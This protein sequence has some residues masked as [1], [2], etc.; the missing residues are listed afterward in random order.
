VLKRVLHDWNDA[1]CVQILSNAH[2]AAPSHAKVLIIE[3]VVPGPET[4]HFSK[5]FDIHMLVM[6][7]GRERTTEEF[8]ELLQRAG[9]KYVHT[10]YPASRML[11]IIEGVKA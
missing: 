1:E 4:P 10:W 8:A 7:T 2:K 9:W 3:A 11:G 5:L 6:L